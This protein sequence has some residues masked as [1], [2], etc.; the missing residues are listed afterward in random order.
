MVKEWGAAENRAIK[1]DLKRVI[2]K[3]AP[4]AQ[5]VKI[6]DIS[7]SRE[8]RRLAKERRGLGGGNYKVTLWLDHREFSLIKD[9]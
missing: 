7:L 2:K 3:P 8:G 9:I 1:G 6:K 5:G 4:R